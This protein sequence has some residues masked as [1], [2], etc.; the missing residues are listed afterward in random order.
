MNTY[1]AV[2]DSMTQAIK[3]SKLLAKSSIQSR[4][5][6]IKAS[7]AYNGCSY[8]LEFDHV[9]YINVNHILTKYGIK[10][11]KYIAGGGFV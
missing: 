5:T 3:A 1:I 2:L 4:V 9:H 11:H 6:Q 8:G 10:V 7:G